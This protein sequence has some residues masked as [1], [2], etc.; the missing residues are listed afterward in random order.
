MVD[1]EATITF[2]EEGMEKQESK[3]SKCCPVVSKCQLVN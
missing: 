3:D 2:I 1:M